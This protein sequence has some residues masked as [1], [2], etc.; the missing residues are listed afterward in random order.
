[1]RNAST[2]S[3][4]NTA[5]FIALCV[6]LAVVALTPAVRAQ[7]K[8][9]AT[10]D[11]LRSLAGTWTC[12]DPYGNGV[13]YTYERDGDGIVERQSAAPPIAHLADFDGPLT[14][15][16]ANAGWSLQARGA[17]VSIEGTAPAWTG[18]NWTV[19]E[20]HRLSYPGMPPSGFDVERSYELLAP[21]TLRIVVR[22]PTAVPRPDTVSGVVCSRGTAPPDASLCALADVPAVVLH[23]ASPVTPALAQQ[24][25]IGG[26][27][28]VDVAVDETGRPGDFHV[29]TS[30]SAVLN[31]SAV[32]AARASAYHAAMH[33]C[34]PVASRYRFSVQYL[35]P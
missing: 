2:S 31:A 23:A 25:G 19:R 8:P 17:N 18:G 30:P 1:M 13:A 35:A 33:D 9:A 6:V 27:V 21:D 22:T 34:R 11:R 16:P 10:T 29:A 20:H 15:R 28:T 14:F 24:Q 32:A 3:A 5:S 4:G 12:R 7:T 26:V